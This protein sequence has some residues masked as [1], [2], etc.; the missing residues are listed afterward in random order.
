MKR[1]A[2]PIACALFAVAASPARASFRADASTLTFYGQRATADIT[3]YRDALLW[4]YDS[5]P[6]DGLFATSARS[7]I[8]VTDLGGGSSE[9]AI[10]MTLS[11]G[12]TW[13]ANLAAA[14]CPAANTTA[15]RRACAD[16]LIKADLKRVW[17]LYD[18]YLRSVSAPPVTAPDL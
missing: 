13:V 1:F 7:N 17:E 10:T 6:L 16:G 8:T 14:P 12:N 5:R 9:L 15:L 4:Y 3:K 18:A 2:L 11:V